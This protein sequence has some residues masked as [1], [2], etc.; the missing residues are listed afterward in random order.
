M[1]TIA[2]SP[3]SFELFI[4]SIIYTTLQ[5][6]YLSRLGLKISLL[7]LAVTISACSNISG[8]MAQRS[9]QL[10]SGLQTAYAVAPNT[11]N[12]LSPMII[13]SSEQH[14]VSP[15]LLAA[16]IR[17]ESN[18]KSSARSPTGAIGLTQIIPSHWRQAC[19]GNLYNENININCGAYVLASY[20]KSAGSWPKALA[21]YNVGP[22]G[23]KRSFWTRQKAKKYAKSVQRHEQA[24]K[25]AL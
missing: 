2:R 12:R 23:Y 20:Y 13:Q 17:Q 15:V 19:P 14:D 11:A 18:Y 5:P 9:K 25:K 10:S 7:L 1:P 24:L 22:T 6:N 16:V 8:S 21:Y 3:V 4:L